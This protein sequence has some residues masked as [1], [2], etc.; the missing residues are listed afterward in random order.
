MK[1][2]FFAFVVAFVFFAILTLVN[3]PQTAQIVTS[4][5]TQGRSYAY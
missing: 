2:A 1:H 5:T 3:D 4:H